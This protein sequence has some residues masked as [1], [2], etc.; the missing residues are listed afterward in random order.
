[1]A[2][3]K[4]MMADMKAMDARLQAKAGRHEPGDGRC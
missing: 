3:R 4:Q 2:E 1:M